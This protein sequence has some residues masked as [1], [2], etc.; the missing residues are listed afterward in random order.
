M[1]ACNSEW[2]L[3]PYYHNSEVASTYYE[4][5]QGRRLPDEHAPFK[6]SSRDTEKDENLGP[7]N[8]AYF[9]KEIGKSEA[10]PLALSVLK[11]THSHC[12]TLDY[13]S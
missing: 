8:L 2:T 1:C 3:I 12:L 9:A 13:S 10:T 6:L 5:Y 7:R 4:H 11:L